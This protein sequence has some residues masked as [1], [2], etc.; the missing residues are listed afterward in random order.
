MDLKVGKCYY[1][2]AKCHPSFFREGERFL[3]KVRKSQFSACGYI[4][5][6]RPNK[7]AFWPLTIYSDHIFIDPSKFKIELFTKEQDVNELIGIPEEIP[8]DKLNEVSFANL[9]VGAT[10]R[11][12]WDKDAYY[13]AKILQ[14]NY[15]GAQIEIIDNG[16][17][18]RIF[19]PRDSFWISSETERRYCLIQEREEK[20][21]TYIVQKTNDGE[22]KIF[23]MR[24]AAVDINNRIAYINGGYCTI[25]PASKQEVL[26]LMKEIDWTDYNEVQLE[27]YLDLCNPDHLSYVKEMR[28]Q[29]DSNQNYDIPDELIKEAKK[30]G[31]KLIC[32]H[33][34]LETIKQRIIGLY[35][36]EK[37]TKKSVK[38]RKH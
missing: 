34:S 10:Y 27:N 14:Q 23:G 2:T 24:N 13:I 3:A 33:N 11:I 22:V 37:A 4:L 6:T 35:L 16:N 25:V 8:F 18:P 19:Y 38:K 12:Y 7:N 21:E 28:A 26:S 30:K 36:S 1:F 20:M 5:I 31:I 29:E 32:G 15:K 9:K 17:S